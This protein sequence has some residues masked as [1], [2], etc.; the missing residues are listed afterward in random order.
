MAFF[1]AAVLAGAAPAGAQNATPFPGFSCESL[2]SRQSLGDTPGIQFRVLKLT[3]APHAVGAIHRH[4]HGEIVY[5]LSGSGESVDAN[6][7]VTPYS[8]DKAL[9]VP[10]NAYHKNVAL[11]PAPLVLLTVQFLSDKGPAFD[12]RSPSG[13]DTCAK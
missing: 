9:V 2:A 11:G 8:S 3:C 6:G 12:P 10:A 5:L 4:R 1:I 13:P 7:K